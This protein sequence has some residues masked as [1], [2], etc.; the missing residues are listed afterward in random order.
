M[1]K[2]TQQAEWLSGLLRRLVENNA[3]NNFEIIHHRPHC[4]LYDD[5]ISF[6]GGVG[7]NNHDTEESMIMIHSM[8][9]H[10]FYCK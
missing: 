10:F 6:L 4:H 9:I 1:E 8:Q 2:G 7:A 5:S 3:T